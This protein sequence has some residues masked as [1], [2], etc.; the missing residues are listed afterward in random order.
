MKGQTQSESESDSAGEGDVE[1]SEIE[2]PSEEEVAVLPD[3]SESSRRHKTLN[4]IGPPL[5][6]VPYCYHGNN[7]YLKYI[8]GV[9]KR[10]RGEKVGGL[11]PNWVPHTSD[12]VPI[13]ERYE[14]LKGLKL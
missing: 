12:W 7:G 2:T 9:L 4:L 3:K 8:R 13:P 14:V 5:A 11:F 10:V 6:N 1:G